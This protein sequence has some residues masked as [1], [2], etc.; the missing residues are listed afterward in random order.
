MVRNEQNRKPQGVPNVASPRK[1]YRREGRCRI[2]P[3]ESA[4]EVGEVAGVARRSRSFTPWRHVVS[5][6]YAQVAH[7]LSLNDVCYA[8]RHHV[9]ILT[10]MRRAV[11]PSRYG[12]SHANRERNADMAEAHGSTEAR[13]VCAEACCGTA[14]GRPRTLAQPAQAYLPGLDI[15]ACGTAT[16]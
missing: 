8:L 12:L 16:G 10:G 14:S 6:V 3:T 11:P 2:D 1:S 7:A 9:S 4:A 5:L 15:I 13:A